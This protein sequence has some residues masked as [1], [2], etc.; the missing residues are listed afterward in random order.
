M[1]T[2]IAFAMAIL[3]PPGI[4]QRAVE[5]GAS[6][7]PEESK[8]LRLG[9]RHLP[10]ITLTQQF[11]RADELAPVLARVEG[12][13][14]DHPPL[15]VHVT[16]GTSVGGAAWMVVEP[17]SDLIGLHERLME[18]LRGFERAEGGPG[19]FVDGDGRLAD[20]LWVDSY[21][22]K[23]ALHAFA[24]HITLGHSSQPPVVEPLAFTA[25][26]IAACH[27]GRFCT[28]ERIL[29]RWTLTG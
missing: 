5:L 14:R 1:S 26:T 27:L 2:L 23:S 8:G 25:D 12:V 17:S 19:A 18:A 28:C 16:G 24:P 22:L 10:H 4:G 6:L 21:R 3:P 11:V 29:R 9:P 20:V 7:P 15:E 13:L